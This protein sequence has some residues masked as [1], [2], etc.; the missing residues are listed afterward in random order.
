M[1]PVQA[2]LEGEG[3]GRTQSLCP[4]DKG[5]LGYILPLQQH[6]D[7][8]EGAFSRKPTLSIHHLPSWHTEG[9]KGHQNLAATVRPWL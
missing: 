9:R 8:V 6:Q 1:L 2:G 5:G 3:V 7:G 4:R